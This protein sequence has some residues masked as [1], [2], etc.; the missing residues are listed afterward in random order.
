MIT[1]SISP[2]GPLLGGISSGLVSAVSALGLTSLLGLAAPHDATTTEAVSLVEATTTTPEGYCGVCVDFDEEG[3]HQ[4]ME[5]L[6]PGTGDGA[7]RDEDPEWHPDEL[8]EGDCLQVHGICTSGMTLY[9]EE[10]SA[11]ELTE[12][13]AAA[14]ARGDLEALLPLVD[15]PGVE[16][17]SQ[18]IAIQVTGCDGETIAGHVPIGLEVL[19]GLRADRVS[20][21]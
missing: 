9:G 5:Y 20:L 16:V 17:V 1:N 21:D 11:G 6:L 14:A 19:D 12:L 2:L 7:G 3:V 18:R 15:L 13:I 10:L 8:M 4:A